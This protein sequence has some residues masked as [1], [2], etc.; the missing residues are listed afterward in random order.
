M[1]TVGFRQILRGEWTKFRTVRSTVWCVL[2][3]LV[4]SVLLSVLAATASRTSADEGPHFIDEFHFVHQPLTGDGTVIA[5]VVSQQRSH[6][7]AKAGVMIKAGTAHGSPYAAIMVTP[8][9]GVRLQSTFDT[10]IATGSERAPSWLKLT[11]AGMSVTGFVSNDG[12]TWR[13]AGSVNVATLPQS[14]EVGMFVT[15]P[16]N[17]VIVKTG[18]GNTG[19][20]EPTVGT[21]VFDNVRVTGNQPSGARWIDDT[22]DHPE[23]TGNR[24]GGSS[25]TGGTFTVS[26]SG[27]VA[28]YGVASYPGSGDDDVVRNSLSGVQIGLMAII[29]LGVLFATSEYK[30]GTI[31]T[32]FAASPRRGR[33]LAAKALVLGGTVFVVGLIASLASFFLSQPIARSRGYVPPAY[34]SASLLDGPVLRA[35]IGT[36]LFLAVLAVFS[37]GI[38]TIRRRTVG[39]IIAVLAVI[40]IP[41]LVAPILSLNAELWINRLTPVAGLAIQQTRERFDTAIAPWAGFA[42]LCAYAAVALGFAMC[43]LRKRDA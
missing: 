16:F 30:T 41:Q 24:A 32:T 3:A 5:H 43:Q 17:V 21:A 33:V 1:A 22:V 38:G 36:A 29:A 12:N 26:G 7:W 15:S 39:A 8:D 28:G 34:P 27:D 18:G 11:R 31:R 4:L 9:H 2:L 25:E 23:A 42:V 19:H 6:E 14:A 35:V 40:V 13:Q 20:V 10:D 37:L